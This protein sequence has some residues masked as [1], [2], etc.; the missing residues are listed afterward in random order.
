MRE[1]EVKPAPKFARAAQKPASK[2]TPVYDD[3]E[4]DEV[5]E[6]E[7][8]IQPVKKA[9]KRP[10]KKARKPE[11]EDE[12]DEDEDD[13]EDVPVYHRS[14]SPSFTKRPPVRLEH[15]DN[16]DDEEY[17]RD[18]DEDDDSYEYEPTPPKRKK[19]GKGNGPLFWILL[20]AIIVVIICIIVAGVLMLTSGKNGLSCAAQQTSTKQTDVAQPGSDPVP[21]SSETNPQQESNDMNTVKVEETVNENGQE[22]LTMSIPA[23]PHSMVTIRIPNQEDQN[24][25][26]DS[27]DPVLFKL[28]ILKSYY[29]P[30]TPVENPQY[31]FT[32]EIF[33]TEQDGTTHQLIVPTQTLTLPSLTIDL[34]QPVPNEEGIIMAD[35]NNLV[36]ISGHINDDSFYINMTVDGQQTLVYTGGFFEAEY[37]MTSDTPTTITLHVEEDNWASATKEITINPYVFVPEKMVLTVDNDRISELKAGSSGTT[38]TV[39][40]TTLP[41]ATLNAESD[42]T[43]KV[44]CTSVTVDETGNYSFDV[45]MN[46]SFY[47]TSL[48]TL[49]AEKEDATSDSTQFYVY[50]MYGDRTAFV[51]GYNPNYKEVGTGSKNLTMAAML[52]QQATYATNN[53][54]FRITAKVDSVTKGEDGYE[55]VQMTLA[56]GETVYVIDF[57]EKW[58]PSSNVGSKYNIYGNFLGTYTDGTTPLFAGYFAMKK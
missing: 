35:K 50:R 17:D 22:C 47:G 36:R 15:E 19:N 40:G 45:T 28:Q 57:G 29:Y 52:A 30:G 41:G 51:K 39:H 56:S 20:V 4:D 27:D 12:D 23:T 53:Y 9:V 26:N 5:D 48:I 33:R 11:P 13:E 7:E 44:V 38:V 8:E 31:Q 24:A 34:E 14:K 42:D 10:V 43:T 37:T 25:P 16:E 2:K 1:E 54:G 6:D 32:P 46:P 49:T 18:E 21:G 3:D 55:Y 58:D